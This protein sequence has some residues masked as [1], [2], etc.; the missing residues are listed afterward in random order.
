MH[1][2][3]RVSRF[4][5]VKNLQMTFLISEPF[6]MVVKFVILIEN[7]L[8]FL[9]FPSRSEFASITEKESC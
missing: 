6:A 8:I 2:Y 9:K 3:K 1:E 4:Y 7:V 5:K